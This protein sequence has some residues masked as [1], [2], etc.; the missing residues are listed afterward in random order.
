MGEWLS[1]GLQIRLQRFDSAPGLQFTKEPYMAD[2][3]TADHDFVR[4]GLWMTATAASFAVMMVSVRVLS[5]KFGVFELVFFRAIIGLLITLPAILSVP[6]AELKTQRLPMHAVRVAFTMFGVSTMFFALG[7][8]PTPDVT[9]ILFLTPLVV[10]CGAALVLSEKVS[11]TRWAATC[12]GFVGALLIIRP[13]FVE[14]GWPT[15]AVLAA[16]VGFAGEWLSVKILS[17]TENATRIVFYLNL[18]L[19]PMALIPASFDWVTPD[20]SDLPAILILGVSGWSAM[21]CQA[22]AFGAA[23]ASSIMPF[24]FLRMPV[25][26]LLSWVL[27]REA[28]DLFTWLGAVIIFGAAWYSVRM[29][30]RQAL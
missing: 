8:L 16:I 3:P 4:G 10:T 6:R 5:E 11:F 19:T 7:R 9:A 12:V 28:G 30:N 15:I 26:A 17:S 29:E 2:A 20:V 23:E 24:D 18:M 21:Y 1:S 22:R 25:V 27:F 14:V 13:G